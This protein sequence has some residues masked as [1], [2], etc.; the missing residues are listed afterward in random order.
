MQIFVKPPDG[1]DPITLY[2]QQSDTIDNVKAL[3]Q[4][5]TGIPRKQQR[6]IFADEDLEGGCTL[7]DCK[8]QKDAMLGLAMLINLQDGC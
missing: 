4:G 5:R 1:Q 6:L 3:I 7:S 8:I 2:V